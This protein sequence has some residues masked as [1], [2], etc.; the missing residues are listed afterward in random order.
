MRNVVIYMYVETTGLLKQLVEQQN[1]LVKPLQ[2]GINPSSP[3][4]AIRLLLDNA[5]LLGECDPRAILLLVLMVW[6]RRREREIRAGVERRIDVDEVY[7]AG[8]FGEQRWQDV[9]LVAPNEPVAPG[10]IVHRELK[11]LV[12]LLGRFVDGLDGLKRQGDAHRRDALALG[13]VL[14]VPDQLG[15]GGHFSRVWN[16]GSG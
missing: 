12:A 6:H 10:V 4:V 7:L 2:I 9:F 11:E 16:E 3:G 14:A 15:A 13:V 1:A 8:E 5:R